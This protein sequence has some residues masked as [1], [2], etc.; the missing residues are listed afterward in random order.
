VELVGDPVDG[1]LGARV[2]RLPV[3]RGPPG[4]ANVVGVSV[5]PPCLRAHTRQ[6][7]DRAL[8]LHRL[9]AHLPLAGLV[10]LRGGLV[11]AASALLLVALRKPCAEPYA[12]QNRGA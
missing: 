7:G 12:G 4:R 8:A 5:C 1:L 9:D 2:L 3:A 6:P 10:R 11:Q